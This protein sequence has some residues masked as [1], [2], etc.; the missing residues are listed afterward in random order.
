MR[1]HP[2]NHLY[3]SHLTH[4][5]LFAATTPTIPPY[6]H[7]YLFI[8][9][10][11][12]ILFSCLVAVGVCALV[13]L[14]YN[15]EKYGHRRQAVTDVIESF[16]LDHPASQRADHPIPLLLSSNTCSHARFQKQPCP[17]VDPPPSYNQS[18]LSGTPPP[19]YSGKM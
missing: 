12:V 1:P 18:V 13:V 15:R 16:A 10:P 8:V 5:F 6:P 2:S 14:L 11:A 3:F 9:V 17:V 4:P 19:P 7:T